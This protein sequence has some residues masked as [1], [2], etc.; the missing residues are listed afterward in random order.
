MPLQ[1]LISP[2]AADAPDLH[3]PTI[4]CGPGIDSAKKC[5]SLEVG[6]T[7]RRIAASDV[8]TFTEQTKAAEGL[9][10]S[11]RNALSELPLT[12]YIRQS[13]L[14]GESRVTFEQAEANRQRGKGPRRPRPGRPGI[15]PWSSATLWRQIH[16]GNFCRPTKLSPKVTAWSVSA[17]RQWLDAQA[18]K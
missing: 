7:S 13:V 1:V 11:I 9:R 2:L 12:A 14:I 6:L 15:I 3:H 17:V 10:E 16:A 18:A 5:Y 8:M 4:S